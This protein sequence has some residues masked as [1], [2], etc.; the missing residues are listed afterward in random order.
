VRIAAEPGRLADSRVQGSDGAIRAHPRLSGWVWVVAAGQLVLLLAM[1]T[2]YGYHRDELY[3][4]VAGG[5][6]AFGYPDQPPLVPLLSW[7]M[8]AIAPS[9]LLLRTPSALAAV[10]TTLLAGLIAREVGGGSRAQIIAAAC[11]ACSAFALAV[12]HLVSTT[13]FDML[14]T[15]VLGYLAI[16]AITRASGRSILAAGV[17]VGVGIEAKPQVGL[18]AAVMVA[19]LLVIG[20]RWP[21]RSWW[22]AGGAACAVSLAAPYLIWQQQH[23]WPQVTVAGNI[24][25]SQEGGRAGFFPFQLLL[26]SPLLVPV[27]VAGLRAPFRRAGWHELRFIPITFAVLAALYFL[28]NGHAYYL[29]SLYPVLLGLG[30]TPTAEWTLRARARTSRL[31]LAIA[32]SATVGA[33]IALPLLPERDL[34]GSVVIALNPTQG[35]MVGWP[36]FVRTVSAAWH[37]IPAGKRV[38]TAIFTKNY[39]EAGAIDI[40]GTGL[41]LPRA[42]S[43][44]NGFSEWGMPRSFDTYAML[45]G[46]NNG[47]DAAPYFDDC[48]TVTVVNDGVGLNN[49][50]QGLPVMLCRTAASWPALWPH[51][52]HYN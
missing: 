34:Q 23:G 16:R 33:V 22:A 5:H 38:H 40:L 48:R 14:S 46:F 26:V 44:H 28:G 6:P 9:L 17:V 49:Q 18:V 11:T 20:P 7:A 37:E 29:A 39:G 27:W 25:G 4:I 35:E 43:G 3:F 45:I 12:A 15:T 42:Y 32:L 52:R 51:L 30:A 21:L 10:I 36:R 8:H 13:T 50:E 19:T 41:R 47:A 2:R 1:S 24:A 31:A